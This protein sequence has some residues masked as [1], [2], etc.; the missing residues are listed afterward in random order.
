MKTV[1]LN[2]LESL[3]LLRSIMSMVSLLYFDKFFLW[4]NMT[5]QIIN[6][7]NTVN[8]NFKIQIICLI[9]FNSVTLSPA[10]NSISFVF[11]LNIYSCNHIVSFI[12]FFWLVPLIYHKHVSILSLNPVTI[13]ND[14]IA[15]YYKVSLTIYLFED[16]YVKPPV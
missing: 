10:F 7:N 13:V 9:T 11:H 15:F 12:T 2:G 4:V 8:E 1:K 5:L 6:S 3:P 16:I 14:Y